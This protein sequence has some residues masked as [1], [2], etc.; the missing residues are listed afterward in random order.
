MVASPPV[1][2]DYSALLLP[3]T[4]AGAV[5]A[6]NPKCGST[7]TNVSL[8][9][10]S[11]AAFQ[12]FLLAAEGGAGL[13]HF[14][15]GAGHVFRYFHRKKPVSSGRPLAGQRSKPRT[16]C[17]SGGF[18]AFWATKIPHSVAVRMPATWLSLRSCASPLSEERSRIPV[19]RALDPCLPAR[20]AIKAEPR[21][22]LPFASSVGAL[23]W[24]WPLG[25][26]PGVLFRNPPRFVPSLRISSRFGR[27]CQIPHLRD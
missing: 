6:A 13:G 10:L 11:R 20:I 7:P 19:G 14:S 17:V 27:F 22:E 21:S 23:V 15:P 12:S 1:A 2:P 4:L 9:G 3:P 5:R 26:T 18:G 8:A 16:K 25:T 24:T